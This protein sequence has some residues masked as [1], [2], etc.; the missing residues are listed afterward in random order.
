MIPQHLNHGM[1][2]IINVNFKNL[3]SLKSKKK[4]RDFVAQKI[5]IEF[6]N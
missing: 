3:G 4:I 5:E 6:R 2:K 1:K